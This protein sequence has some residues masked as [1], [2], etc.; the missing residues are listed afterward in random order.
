MGYTVLAYS[1]Q[2]IS[3]MHF[4]AKATP[5]T[6]T[7]YSCRIKAVKLVNQSYGVQIMP[8]INS[9]GGGHTHTHMHVN[10]QSN[11]KKSGMWPAQN[12]FK[13]TEILTWLHQYLIHKSK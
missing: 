10:R 2:V 7:K 6:N 8:V 1:Y 12:W 4:N 9:F 13:N 11:F 3:T 5:T